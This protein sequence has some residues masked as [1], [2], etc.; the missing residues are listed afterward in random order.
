M[1]QWSPVLSG[2]EVLSHTL[3]QFQVRDKLWPDSLIC[4]ICPTLPPSQLSPFSTELLHQLAAPPAQIA[5]GMVSPRGQHPHCLP[6]DMGTFVSQ[7]SLHPAEET[8]M[9]LPPTV[10]QTDSSRQ[11]WGFFFPQKASESQQEPF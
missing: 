2:T 11:G 10:P 1:C 4:K 6:R 3:G 5:L 8:E 7:P 9:I